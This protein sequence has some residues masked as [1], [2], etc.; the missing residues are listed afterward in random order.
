MIITNEVSTCLLII[1]RR[2]VL[3]PYQSENF[4]FDLQ[5]YQEV[6]CISL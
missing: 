4:L 3:V 2:T 5:S 1:L 6:Q